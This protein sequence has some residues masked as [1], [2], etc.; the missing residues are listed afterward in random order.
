M[1]SDALD[2]AYVEM[3][4]GYGGSNVPAI[5]IFPLSYQL[6]DWNEINLIQM[7][8]VRLDFW[9]L[10]PQVSN[11]FRLVTSGLI[12]NVGSSVSYPTGWADWNSNWSL[13]AY[14]TV[15][16]FCGGAEIDQRIR[17]ISCHESC[18]QFEL[19]DC[20]H[21]SNIFTSQHECLM[22]NSVPC[23]DSVWADSD[24]GMYQ[25]T[26]DPGSNPSLPEYYRIRSLANPF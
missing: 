22:N 14:D 11:H 21:S 10:A 19:G 24:V 25:E 3:K 15:T 1:I 4:S 13:V 23:E 5:H 12:W 6:I 7:V 20:V 8:N 16:G 26:G 17:E 18:H 9:G 2:E